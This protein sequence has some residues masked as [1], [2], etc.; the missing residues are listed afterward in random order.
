MLSADEMTG[1][2]RLDAPRCTTRG[3]QSHDSFETA[4]QGLLPLHC[5]FRHVCELNIPSMDRLA[6][7]SRQLRIRPESPG[8]S[9]LR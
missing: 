7:H 3:L 6:L 1:K 4:S 5:V 8:R 2:Y 9:D